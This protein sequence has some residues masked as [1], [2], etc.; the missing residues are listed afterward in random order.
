MDGNREAK[1]RL[2]EDTGYLSI[3]EALDFEVTTSYVLNISAR[4]AGLPRRVAYQAL[5]ITV[6][7]VNDNSPVFEKVLD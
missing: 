7:D 6:T 1:F 4:D 3:A 5:T 2:D